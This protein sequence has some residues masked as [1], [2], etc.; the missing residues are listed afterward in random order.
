[1][2]QQSTSPAMAALK[3]GVTIGLVMLVISFLIYFIDYS[4]LV[5]AWYGFAVFVLFFGLVIYYGI[6]YRK[7]IGG[8]MPYGPAFQFAF[9][10][11]IVSG[12]I[13]TLGNIVLYQLI[14]PGLSELLVKV[15]LE[16]MLAMLDNF[17]AGDNISSD[18]I[19]EMRTEMEDAFTFAGQIKGFGVSLII[20]AIF[21]LILGAIIKKRDKSTDF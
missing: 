7:E 2:E 13:S 1:M 11:L 20:Y 16:N 19:N 9:V 21:S 3:S 6:Q 17:G 18:Q 15:Q 10:T 8:F 12:L 14:D 4:L 5:A